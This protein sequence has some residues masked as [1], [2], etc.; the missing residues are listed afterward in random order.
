[1]QFWGFVTGK[2]R[3]DVQDHG[4]VTEKGKGVA[5]VGL[6]EGEFEQACAGPRDGD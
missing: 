3:K 6:R 4:T 5:V 2:L 1:M